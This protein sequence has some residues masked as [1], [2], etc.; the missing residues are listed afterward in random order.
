MHIYKSHRIIKNY[1]GKLLLKAL[2]P[3]FKVF[4]KSVHLEGRNVFARFDE[5]LLMTL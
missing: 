1:K 3:S 2:A 5:I 4:I